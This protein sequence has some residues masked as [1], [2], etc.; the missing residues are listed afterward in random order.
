MRSVQYNGFLPASLPF[1]GP[2]LQ[3]SNGNL[4]LTEFQVY[5]EGR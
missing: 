3:V 2:G 5:V 1:D 4:V